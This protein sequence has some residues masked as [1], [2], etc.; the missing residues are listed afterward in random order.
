[1]KTKLI[2]LLLICL[3]SFQESWS[4]DY[5]KT[6]RQSEG[7]VDSVIT[8]IAIGNDEVYIATP[9][10]FSVFKDDAFTNYDTSNSNLNS[11]NIS[12]IIHFQDTVWMVTDSGLSQYFNGSIQNYTVVD[13]LINDTIRDIEVTS[14]G[15]LWIATLRGISRKRGNN[16]INDPSKKAY[17]LGINGGDSVYAIVNFGSI[18]TLPNFVS[19][20]MFDG[21][22]WKSVQDNNLS[23]PM[24]VRELVSLENGEIIV[25]TNVRGAFRIENEF[26][27]Q[28]LNIPTADISSS[29]LRDIR[30]TDSTYWVG[31]GNPNFA[32]YN[33]DK[34]V[35]LV[36]WSD[37][38]SIYRY[39]YNGLPDVNILSLAID[40]EKIYIGTKDG[41][42]IASQSIEV[43]PRTESI[44]NS[45]LQAWFDSRG[46]LFYNPEDDLNY[47][48][49]E[50][51]LNS[52]KYLMYSSSL[53]LYGQNQLGENML[54]IQEFDAGDYG[55]GSIS[56]NS[57]PLRPNM[58]K[59]SSNDIRYHLQNFNNP[60]YVMPKSILKWP[61]NGFEERGEAADQ[62][63]FVDAN[64]NGCYDPENGD[65]PFILGD[66]A[67]YIIINDGV[68]PSSGLFTKNMDIEVHIMAYVFNQPALQHANQSVYVRYTLVN[69]SRF[70]YQLKAGL[71]ADS[72][73]G[74]PGDDFF[75]SE[76]SA[77]SI[78]FYNALAADGTSSQLGWPNYDSILP[79]VGIKLINEQMSSA[80]FMPFGGSS[81]P[82]P[83]PMRTPQVPQNFYN[84][85]NS[86]WN[87][88]TPFTKGGFGYNPNS[89][90]ATNFTF[91]GDPLKSNTWSMNNLG[92]SFNYTA[93]GDT[94]G[95]MT[96]QEF[97]FHPKERKIYDLVFSVAYDSSVVYDNLAMIPILKNQL[98][99]AANFQRGI[100]SIA[101]LF[102]YSSCFVGEEENFLPQKRDPLLLYPNPNNGNF[103]L[104][105][106]ADLTTIEIYNVQGQLVQSFSPSPGARQINIE[107]NS[108]AKDGLFILRAIATDG[109]VL[110]KRI[111]LIP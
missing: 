92:P 108:T 101:P 6:Y 103:T 2:L 8:D 110:T 17:E 73:L 39:H 109:E 37:I 30:K 83:S 70:V 26:S 82:F 69:R 22:S 36:E 66:E 77:S 98:S 104:E 25:L 13:G 47:G 10:G 91:S 53:W 44:Q 61:A 90:D 40:D 85:F 1:M 86:M 93:G 7:L 111:L 48:N 62:A 75:G 43:F 96:F 68:S 16:F 63:P 102:T 58:I 51:P 79:A 64:N 72:D 38:N 27:L 35:G 65:Y 49:L 105:T 97:T 107:I 42:S 106:E 76:P 20:E 78:F 18:F 34:K 52:G 94:R 5:W 95:F 33:P 12:K 74:N 88:G 56:E 80:S 67:V 89:S 45:S 31:Y 57:T 55:A 23:L 59:I 87:D 15:E 21:T 9:R 46:L 84:R 28:K 100:D 19:V 4:Q 81:T 3:F 99:K 32:Q 29:F 24:E 50:F 11:H 54:A 14:T 71:F 60:G 41:F